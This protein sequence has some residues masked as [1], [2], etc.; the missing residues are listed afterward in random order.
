MELARSI[1]VAAPFKLARDP[2]KAGRL[3]T[4]LNITTQGIYTA[5]AGLLPVLPHKAIEGLSQ[6][7][8]QANGRKFEQLALPLA[9]GHVLTEGTP[10]FQ[11]STT[12]YNLP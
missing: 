7:G 9:D 4:V 1:E 6:L 12:G 11:R 10:L 8:V 2:A 5:M 3:D